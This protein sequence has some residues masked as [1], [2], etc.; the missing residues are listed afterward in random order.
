MSTRTARSLGLAM[1]LCW[2]LAPA[3]GQT[4]TAV[5]SGLVHDSSGARVPGALVT[6]LHVDTGAKHETNANE[7]GFYVLTPLRSGNYTLTVEAA[8]FKTEVRSGLTLQVQQKA[9][10]DIVLEVGQI[11]E[12]VTVEG[13]VP[14]LNAVDASLG[15]V[16]TNR[17]IVELPLNGRNYLQLAVLA[18]GIGP[19]LK[20]RFSDLESTFVANGLRVNM[21]NF[22]LDGVDNNSQIANL[23]SGGAEVT[24][25]SIDAIQEF[26]MQTSNFSAGFGRSAGAVINVTTRSGSNTFHGSAYS[27]HR[28][29]ALDAKNFFDR[30]DDP[31]PPFIQ[32]QFG[33]TLGGPVARDR[34]YFFGSWE[35]SRQ[36]KALTFTS[37]VPT[38]AQRAGGFRRAPDVRSRKYAAESGGPVCARTIPE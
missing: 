7:S 3:A 35:G 28:N 10:I 36:R 29:A 31:I 13:S 17:S 2:A 20:G 25:P 33:G 23:Q 24:R 37:T 32:N 34:S 9:G 30:P 26:K 16:I 1:F 5:I 21:N 19:A 12:Q 4:D 27:F 38:A 8:G 15:Q 22:L 18:A 6:A 14:L 11:S